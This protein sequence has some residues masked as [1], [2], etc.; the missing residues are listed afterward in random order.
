MYDFLD[1]ASRT[2]LFSVDD[3]GLFPV[4]C[5]IGLIHMVGE[6]GLTTLC[7]KKTAPLRQVDINSSK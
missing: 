5:M 3:R 4:N 6:C 7:L 1:P 2:V